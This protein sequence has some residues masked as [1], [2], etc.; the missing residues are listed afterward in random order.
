MAPTTDES[1]TFVSKYERMFRKQFST[2]ITHGTN[3]TYLHLLFYQ[4]DHLRSD[5]TANVILW[6]G[7]RCVKTLAESNV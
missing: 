7:L 5:I 2:S 4:F 6:T 1:P 3:S